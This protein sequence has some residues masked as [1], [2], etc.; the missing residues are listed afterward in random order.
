VTPTWYDLLGVDSGASADEIRTAWKAAIADL[1]PTD[2]RFRTLN[3]AAEVL[4]DPARRAEYD[5]GL[6]PEAD[7]QAPRAEADGELD[8][9]SAEQEEQDSRATSRLRVPAWLLAALAILTAAALA[10]A[11][12]LY[13]QPSDGAIADATTGAQSAAE[14]AVTTILAYDYRHLDADQKSADELMTTSYQKKYDPLF[15]QIAANAPDLKAVVTVQVVAS[16]I[17]RSGEDR[18]QVLLFVNRPTTRADGNQLYRDQVVMTMERSGD[19]WLVDD[20]DTN[21]LAS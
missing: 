15:S 7:E 5:A 21:Q 14:H 4:L 2:R 17:V 11:G 20:M 16:G 10:A 9:P 3:E 6:E 1:D 13:S 8:A 18:V 12:Y 19:D